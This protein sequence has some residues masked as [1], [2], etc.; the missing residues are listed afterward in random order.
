MLTRVLAAETRHVHL[1]RQPTAG[2]GVNVV[3]AFILG[4]ER[5]Q[6]LQH[7]GG[8]PRDTHRCRSAK[9]LVHEPTA[10]DACSLPE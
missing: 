6:G 10:R 5:Q 8:S 2:V 4:A 9:A 3:D 1:L 7:R